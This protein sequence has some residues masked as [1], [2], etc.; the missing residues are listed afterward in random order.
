LPH[1]LSQK[2]IEA[3]RKIRFEPAVK[4]GQPVNVRGN[5]EFHFKL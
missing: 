3:A 2:A 5:L 1:G 4:D